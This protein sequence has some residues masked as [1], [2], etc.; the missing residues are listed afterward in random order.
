MPM[1][2]QEI[3]HYRF[4]SVEVQE[5]LIA[6][7]ILLAGLVLKN[8]VSRLLTKVLFR[9]FKAK[10]DE[11]VTEA[12][13]HQLL[14]KPIS[15]VIFLITVFIAYTVMD[16][17]VRT[18]EL[19][20][21]TPWYGV[22]AFRVYQIAF[23]TGITWIFLRMIDLAVLVFMNRALR[24][25]SRL[26]NQLVPFARDL[27][28]LFVAIVAFLIILGKV[29][30]VD[31][32]AVVGGLGIGGLAVAFAAKESLENLLASFT[33]FLDQPFVVGDLVSVGDLTGSVE[34][35]GFRSTRIRTVEKSY[36]TVPNK[37]MIDKPLDNLSRRTARRVFFMMSL[38][39]M[40][41]SDQL[42]RILDQVRKAIVEHRLI[43]PDVQ[44][45]FTSLTSNSKDVRVQYYVHTNSYD[46]YLDVMEEVNFKIVSAVEEVGASF[47]DTTMTRLSGTG[48]GTDLPKSLQQS[49]NQSIAS[50]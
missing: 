8:L 50:S 32:T 29:F 17:P 31:V 35:I 20:R 21:N 39:Q 25:P 2:V 44:V 13:F 1:S 3:L 14:I 43:T 7:V 47:V 4:L 30:D 9:F 33:I 24:D 27:I 45:K 41:T 40:T 23:I 5:Y 6:A 19:G 26:T 11:D 22:F 48:G 42:H 10:V 36:V 37:S 12:Q 15:I 18:A 38:T 28:K 49:G 46:E 16:I 34:K